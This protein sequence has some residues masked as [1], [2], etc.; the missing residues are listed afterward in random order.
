METFFPVN[1]SMHGHPGTPPDPPLPIQILNCWPGP[2]RQAPGTHSEFWGAPGEPIPLFPSK[3]VALGPNF[4]KNRF[5][6]CMR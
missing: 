1:Y 6:L 5:G 2:A 4:G 3:S